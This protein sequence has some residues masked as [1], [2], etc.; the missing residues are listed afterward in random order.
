MF[1][2]LNKWH[3]TLNIE[4]L[5][6][7]FLTEFA[8]LV[9]YME[10]YLQGREKKKQRGKIQNLKQNPHKFTQQIHEN[11]KARAPVPSL[12]LDPTFWLI[13]T[14]FR[15]PN[16][17]KKKRTS[18]VRRRYF[19]TKWNS[20]ATEPAFAWPAK[21]SHRM[22]KPSIAKHVPPPGTPRVSSLH[23]RSCQIRSNGSALTAPW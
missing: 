11:P 13:N 21:T 1:F 7:N 17:C 3:T 14:P 5:V 12:S 9:I 19:W 4:I 23:L 8:I 10:G 20:H 15:K 2:F 22:K 6:V 16:P 18:Q